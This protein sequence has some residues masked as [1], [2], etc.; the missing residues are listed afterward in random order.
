MNASLRQFRTPRL[1]ILIFFSSLL[2]ISQLAFGQVA[3]SV[4]T[5]TVTD[6]SGATVPN[7][8]VKVFSQQIEVSRRVIT[9]SDGSY[10]ISDLQPGQYSIL[11]EA[12]GF[13]KAVIPQIVLYVGQTSTQNIR[14]QI[15]G[16][17][18]EVTITGQAPL[19]NTSNGQLG[20]VITPTLMAQL[21]L[22]GRNLMQ[23]NLLSPGAI[24][25]K[26]GNTSSQVSLSPATVTFSVNGHMSDFNMYLLDGIEIKDWQHGTSMFAPSVDAVQEFQTTTSNYSAAF[27]AEAAAQVNLIVKSG[28]NQLHGAL[29]EYLRNNLFD[30]RDFFQPGPDPPFRRNQFGANLGGP[31]YLPHIY[32][33]KQR[34]FFFFNYEGFRQVKQVPE[35]GYYPTS[36]QLHGDLSGVVTP[37]TPLIN[38][39]SGAPFAG[40]IIPASMIRPSSL[41]NFLDTGI[42]KG[43]WIPAPNADLPGINY[44]HDS[45]LNYF[46]NQYIARVDHNITDNTALYGHFTWNTELRDDPNLNP[47]WSEYEDSQTY[48]ASAHLSHVF[49]PNFVFEVATGYTHFYQDLVQSTAGV[50]NISNSILGINGSATVPDAWGAPVWNVA[51][52]SNLGEVNFGPRRWFVNVFDLRPAFT[53]TSGKHTLRWGLDFQRVNEDFQEIFR[54]NG[55]WDY[56]GYFSGYALGDFLLGLPN[57]IN[58]SPDPF[59]PNVYNSTFGPN[60]TINLGLRYEWVGIPL[61]HNHRSISNIYFPPDNGVPVL[62]VADDAGPIKFDGVQESLFTGDPFVRAS[63]VR[64]PEQLAYNDN[65]D[66]SPRLGFAYRLPGTASTVVRGGYGLFYSENIQDQWLESAVDPP[67][68]RSDLTVVDSTNFR[69]FDPTNPY[70]NAVASAAQLFGNDINHRMGRTQEWNLTLE[71]TQ[72]N[73]LFSAAYVGNLSD[74]LTDLEDPN[75]AAPGPGSV[76]AR[77]A[78]PTQGVLYLAGNNGIANYNSLQLKAQHSFA[79]GLEFLAS[80]TRSKTLDS[81]DGTFVGEGGRGF[82]TQDFLN[83]H[84]E[85]GL[86]AQDVGQAFV[87]SYLYQ[88]PFGHGRMFLNRTGLA[89][90]L[91]G[92]WQINGIVSAIAGDPFTISQAANGANTDVGTFRPNAVSNPVLPSNRPRGEMVAEFFNTA[93]FVEN[94]PIDGVYQFGNTARN[95]VIG[96][97]TLDCDLSLF[98]DFNLTERGILQFRAEAFNIFNR[99]IFAQPGAELGTPTF[100]VLTS[101]AIDPREI[102][103][104]LRLSF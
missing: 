104:A 38:P 94:V 46:A 98:K 71:R 53:R 26:T 92:G 102:Q 22:N 28:T 4:L 16:A 85:Y 84:T 33:G 44:I 21:P 54:T 100:G 9:S 72:W 25:D 69:T 73:T 2:S 35:T 32:H 39:F 24:T 68:V 3:V 11:V 99:P 93:A 76:D 89:N 49:S 50:N 5:G 60:L 78:W 18:Q 47:N 86:A 36:A 70:V 43:P 10:T 34:T 13:A 88:L 15:G 57:T 59:A 23:L 63:S 29:W 19:L 83:R 65:L 77:R 103:F 31:V 87:F 6:P 91:F 58:S 64:L 40:N 75:Q 56:N 79:N 74:H 14:L 30:A 17:K 45:G 61:S 80:Y 1:L 8:V 95:S 37:G 96:P 82:D 62:V 51:G 81:S 42:G 12:P 90:A 66:F 41:L 48:S 52:Y 67:F 97:G 101:T 27:G 20:T 55:I 7:A